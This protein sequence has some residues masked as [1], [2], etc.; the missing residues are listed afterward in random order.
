MLTSIPRL[1]CFLLR[2]PHTL[3]RRT[4]RGGRRL[5]PLLILISRFLCSLLTL[6]RRTTRGGRRLG[7][8]TNCDHPLTFLACAQKDYT[9]GE[10]TGLPAYL[11]H[12]LE[13]ILNRP[14]QTGIVYCLSRDESETVAAQARAWGCGVWG[15][16]ERGRQGGRAGHGSTLLPTPD[17]A[18]PTLP[19]CCFSMPCYPPHPTPTHMHADSGPHG[20]LSRA[21]PRRDDP[22]PAHAGAE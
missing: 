18:P 12:M 7:S 22:P 9:R 16:K 20:G 19:P 13:Y 3:R 15:K 8:P 14:D 10:E 11:E 6:H 21:L 1:L 5:A 4:T 2:S 17:A